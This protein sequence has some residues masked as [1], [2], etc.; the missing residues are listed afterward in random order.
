MRLL[1]LVLFAFI[2]SL[3][4]ESLAAQIAP[5]P[6]PPPSSIKD[7]KPAENTNEKKEGK[8]EEK[9][10]NK[11]KT[12]AEVTKSSKKIDGLFPIYQDTIKGNIFMEIRADQLEKEYI[13]FFHSENGSLNAG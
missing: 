13:H 1:F 2:S 8:D 5:L 11:V 9:D 3:G 7:K 6:P 12:I 4:F 10:K